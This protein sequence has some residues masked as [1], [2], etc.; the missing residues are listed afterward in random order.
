MD[1]F[2]NAREYAVYLETL[3][4]ANQILKDAEGVT[5]EDQLRSFRNMILGGDGLKAAFIG[6]LST[7]PTVNL[8]ELMA[9]GT[10]ETEAQMIIDSRDSLRTRALALVE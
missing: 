2:Q 6:T 7:E 5:D 10:K 9:R 1:I 3:S 4:S 8:D